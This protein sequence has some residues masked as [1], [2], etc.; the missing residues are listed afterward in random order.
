MVLEAAS[1][2]D[3]NIG[4]HGSVSG[5][6]RHLLSADAVCRSAVHY[7]PADLDDT[8]YET[9]RAGRPVRM[10]CRF[11]EKIGKRQLFFISP[12]FCPWY[13][14]GFREICRIFV[15]KV[16]K[17]GREYEKCMKYDI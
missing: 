16:K 13:S 11:H 7:F 17:G 8:E 6:G 15:Q 4:L 1:D 5:C 9:L 12:H 10:G 2:P 3:R 14:S